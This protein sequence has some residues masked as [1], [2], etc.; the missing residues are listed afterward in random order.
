MRKS[1][2]ELSSANKQR[3]ASTH[4]PHTQ[5]V[6]QSI[7]GG[8]TSSGRDIRL[9][10]IKGFLIILVVLGHT[11]E[12][13]LHST[14]NIL[15]YLGIYS[16]H[17]P[18]FVI[19]S[20]FFFN[21]SQSKEKFKRSIVEIIETFFVFNSVLLVIKWYENESLSFTDIVSPVWIMW[22]IFSLAVWRIS[23]YFIVNQFKID[24]ANFKWML[25][26][27]IA[28][29][30][31]GLIPMSNELA[32]QR[33]ITFYPYFILGM[34]LRRRKEYNIKIKTAYLISAFPILLTLAYAI[35]KSQSM[36]IDTLRVYFYCNRFYN[37]FYDPILR[38]I[39]IL[40]GFCTSIA[41][42]RI[43]PKSKLL[44]YVGSASLVIYLLH[45]YIVSAFYNIVDKGLIPGDILTLTIISLLTVTTLCGVGN[46]I[47]VCYLTNPISALSKRLF[48]W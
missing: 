16:F 46:L 32:L 45:P 36:A 17:M 48:S 5:R 34:I 41:L 10:S 29:L 2:T 35:M 39:T 44:A 38:L 33:T 7:G 13:Y 1:G 23:T 3:I 40:I 19:L 15:L 21:T 24:I 22:Y 26:A 31:V 14:F 27:I 20:G 47:K 42:F 43:F 9:D 30:L 18:L 8:K 4:A 37:T 11:I 25:C 6:T 12:H 28:S